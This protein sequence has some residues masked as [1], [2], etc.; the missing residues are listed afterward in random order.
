MKVDTLTRHDERL[1]RV[2]PHIVA[3]VRDGTAAVS[4]E[5]LAAVSHTAPGYLRHVLRDQVGEPPHR[6]VRRLRMSLAAYRLVF[7]DRGVLDIAVDAGYHSHAAFTRA[8]RATYGVP[9]SDLRERP[10]EASRPLAGFTGTQVR[11]ASFPQRQVAC[12]SRFGARDAP[13]SAWDQLRSWLT[14]QGHCPA[15]SKA[16][17]V[18]RD[19]P[20]HLMGAR[21]R[22]TGCRPG[23]DHLPAHPPDDAGVRV[24]PA[25]AG[26]AMRHTGPPELI[27]FTYM[28]LAVSAV[29]RGV[30]TPVRP[31]LPYYVEFT[32]FPSARPEQRVSM[33]VYLI[34]QTHG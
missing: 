20:D 3:Q 2:I 6:F 4:L 15:R 5:D 18:C 17:G 27:P 34:P 7:G 31:P 16:L 19:D 9:P 12:W 24:V 1:L 13:H 8:F 29:A 28:D 22:R 14:G 26:I 25:S 11:P 10:A 32:P 30:Q 23:P 33:D 21:V